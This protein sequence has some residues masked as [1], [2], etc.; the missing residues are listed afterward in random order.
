MLSRFAG[1]VLLAHSAWVANA[2]LTGKIIY[3]DISAA[4]GLLLCWFSPLKHVIDVLLS[5]ALSHMFLNLFKIYKDRN[6]NKLRTMVI[7]PSILKNR[8]STGS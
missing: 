2:S 4:S 7:K 8:W 3:A 5:I 1:S 6:M